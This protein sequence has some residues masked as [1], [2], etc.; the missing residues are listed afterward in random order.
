MPPLFWVDIIGLC[1]SILIAGSLTLLIIGVDPRNQVNRSFGLFTGTMAMWTGAA[2]LLRLSLW[3]EPVLPTGLFLPNPYLWLVIATVSVPLICIVSL[4][5]TVT[6]LNLRT[7]WTDLIIVSGLL[8]LILFLARSLVST[9]AAIPDVRLDANGLVIHEIRT[10]A[11]V[12]TGVFYLYILGSIILF[13]RERHRTGANYLAMSLL[14]LLLGF[15]FRSFVYAPFPILAFSNALCAL[16]LAYGVISRQIF[17][18]SRVRTIELNK[19]IGERIEAERLLEE[20]E[21]KARAIF[22]LSF[23]FAVPSSW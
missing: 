1:I 6:Y 7:R 2:L 12:M 15:V 4:M 10:A 22:D 9:G 3:L 5:F 17:N 14:I 23:G 19:E 13:W 16:I 11:Q 20:S 21:R 18:P 8:L